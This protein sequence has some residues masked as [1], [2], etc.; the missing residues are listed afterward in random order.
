MSISFSPL[1]YH[2]TVS[3]VLTPKSLEKH[4]ADKCN[5]IFAVIVFHSRITA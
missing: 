4:T 1:I 5:C 2:L 3:A